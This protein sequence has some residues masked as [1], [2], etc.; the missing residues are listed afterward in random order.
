MVNVGYIRKLMEEHHMS[1]GQ[2]A[3]RTG[4]SKSQ[5]SRVL[6]HKRGIGT[7]AMIGLKKAFPNADMN[8]IF[9]P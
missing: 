2:L 7:R 8:K 9:L 4:V 6:A 3:I 1:L 5:W